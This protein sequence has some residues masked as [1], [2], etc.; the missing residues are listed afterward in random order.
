MYG[1]GHESKI[2]P[3][4]TPYAR[5]KYDFQTARATLRQNLFE[6]FATENDTKRLEHA[7]LVRFYE[8]LDLSENAAFEA[9][10]AYI[11]VWRYRQLVS[12]AEENYATHRVMYE[13]IKERA[14]S[15]VGRKVDLET[16][17][18]RLALSESN[19]LT[20]TSNLH[21]VTARFQRVVGELPPADMEAPPASLLGTELPKDRASAIT[22]SLE[23]SPQ[24]KAAFENILSALR[25]IE[26]QKA[27]YYP[28]V[29][30]YIEQSHE[31]GTGG[32][33]TA[34]GSLSS[35][36]N[37]TTYTGNA[38]VSASGR[39]DGNCV[40]SRQVSPI[41]TIFE[42]E[43]NLE[44][45]SLHGGVD[46]TREAVGNARGIDGLGVS[47]DY[48][49]CH[50]GGRGRNLTGVGTHGGHACNSTQDQAGNESLFH[51]LISSLQ[52][53]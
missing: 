37:T 11:D 48:F 18:G 6:G 32:Y 21:D 16:A 38:S 20:E 33:N 24:M 14:S 36:T 35:A 53:K 10:K 17:G 29:D 1:I 45:L 44:F 2:S 51:R 12:Y 8:M 40:V 34:Y 49:T 50:I 7:T 46:V 19:L 9:T 13:K 47:G 25:Q 3:L 27:G 52:K 23:K 42:R 4:Y 39:G 15:G 31:N 30:A 5:R 41:G 43:L 28:R 26:V 22:T